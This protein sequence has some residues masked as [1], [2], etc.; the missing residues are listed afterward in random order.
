MGIS[1]SLTGMELD[2]KTR[3][4]ME[5]FASFMARMIEK[6]GKQVLAEIEAEEKAKESQ[7]K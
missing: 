6:Y 4:N 2:E 3:Y 5:K 7:K 1:D